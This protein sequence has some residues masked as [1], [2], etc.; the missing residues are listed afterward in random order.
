[1]VMDGQFC[2]IVVALD[3]LLIATSSYHYAMAFS[4]LDGPEFSQNSTEY[5]SCIGENASL[6]C[7]AIGRPLPDVSLYR[8]GS[9]L[10][11]NTGSVT[12]LLP[13]DSSSNFGSYICISNNTVGVANITT[14]FKIKRKFSNEQCVCFM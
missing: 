10:G 6:T 14:T 12:H 11:M 1:M 5:Q 13:F 8:N 3:L 7:N 9:L 4:F 2:S